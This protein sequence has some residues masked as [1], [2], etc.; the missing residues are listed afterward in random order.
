MH[1]EDRFKD[2]DK[3]VDITLRVKHNEKSGL[4]NKEVY[5]DYVYDGSVMDEV[6]DHFKMRLLKYT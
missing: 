3:Y 4:I 1:V 2:V 5:T 6:V